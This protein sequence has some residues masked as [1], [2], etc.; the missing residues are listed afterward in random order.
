MRDYH[1]HEPIIPEHIRH[2]RDFDRFHHRDLERL[3]R[4]QAW[5]E[6]EVLRSALARRVFNHR[7]ERVV[8]FDADRR[9]ITDQ[10]WL[11]RRIAAL[12]HH[13]DRRTAA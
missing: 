8:G 2:D 5:A 7:R 3:T 11:R 1:D 13:L 10:E 6:L 4:A 12:S 9:P